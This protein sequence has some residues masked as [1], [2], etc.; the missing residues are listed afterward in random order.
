MKKFLRWCGFVLASLV[1]LAVIAYGLVYL[2]SARLLARTYDIPAVAIV[3]PTDQASL[4]EGKRLATVYGC[5]NGCHGKE[6]A[7]AVMFDQPAIMRLVAPNLSASVRQYTDAQLA[8]LIRRG[9]RP[10]GRSTIVMPSEAFVYM[11]D[12]DLGRI[13]AFLKSM[14]LVDG[15]GPSVKLGPIGRI[16]VATGKLATT[17]QTMATSKS[18]PDAEGEQNTQGRYLA[19]L[20]CAQCHGTNLLGGSTPAFTSPGLQSVAAYSPEAFAQLMRTGVALGNRTLETM[21]PW[22]RDNLSAMTDAEIAALYS[23]LRSVAGASGS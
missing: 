4:D 13:L 9:L 3:V 19:Q 18:P 14:P 11:T 12:G 15:P 16:G 22:A 21:S 20:T 5:F 17:V 2:V 1:G 6:I 7:G 10:D 23:Y 8:T